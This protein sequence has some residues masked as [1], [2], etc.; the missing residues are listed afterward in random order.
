MSM[1]PVPLVRETPLLLT[2]G[3]TIQIV[4]TGPADAREPYKARTQEYFYA[5][6][7]SEGREILGFHWTPNAV[8][9]NAV[10]FPHLHIGSA[11]LA[12][13]M[14][15]RPKD[16]HKAHIPTGRVSLEAVVRLAITEFRVTPLRAD[17]EVVLRRTE[18]AFIRWKTR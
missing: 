11:L 3:Q 18:D 17:W 4:K 16:L 10:T 13:Q 8:G 5:F 9:E 1:D 2:V 14:V 7:T 15:I 6:S 12:G